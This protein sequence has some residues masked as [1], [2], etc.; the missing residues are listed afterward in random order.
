MPLS[1]ED[2]MCI[3]KTLATITT[4]TFAC[5]TTFNMI[6]LTPTQLHDLKVEEALKVQRSL[7]KR[8]VPIVG[9]LVLGIAAS[10]SV[11]AFS[12]NRKEDLPWLIGGGTLAAVF[13]YT[14]A[15]LSPINSRISSE[16]VPASEGFSVLRRWYGFA[17]GRAAVTF[18]VFSYFT[19]LLAR[20]S[21]YITDSEPEP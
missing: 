12:K 3:L 20:S 13:P 11:Y 17:R 2:K 1:Q 5:G 4:G 7:N 18:G 15:L 9:S 8:I 14:M 10:S 16:Q 21:K 6:I 19:Y